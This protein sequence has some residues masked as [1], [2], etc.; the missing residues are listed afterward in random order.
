M[1]QVLRKVRIPELVLEIMQIMY[2][3]LFLLFETAS[4]MY[5]AQQARGGQS[6]F[7]SR[8]KDTATLIVQ[9]FMKTLHQ[10]R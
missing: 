8:L 5:L 9:M 2:R 1:L 6:G 10:Y 7:R 3:F 4:N